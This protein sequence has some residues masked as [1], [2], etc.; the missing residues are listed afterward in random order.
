MGEKGAINYSKDY[1]DLSDSFEESKN[2][3]FN[4]YWAFWM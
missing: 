3:V 4:S 1:K 2:Q